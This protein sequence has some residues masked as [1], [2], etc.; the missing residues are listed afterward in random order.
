MLL[1]FLDVPENCINLNLDFFP[2]TS[3]RLSLVPDKVS[4]TGA[5]GLCLKIIDNFPWDFECR[6]K[7]ACAYSDSLLSWFS[8]RCRGLGLRLFFAFP[9]PDDFTRILR[10]SGW[11]H[12]RRK[13]SEQLIIDTDAVGFNRI[14]DELSEDFTE[15]CGEI[16]GFFFY[17]EGC[18]S[19]LEKI[20]LEKVRNILGD[21]GYFVSDN[22]SSGDFKSAE[23]FLSN[24]SSDAIIQ[25]AA[26]KAAQ[27]RFA[28]SLMQIKQQLIMSSMSFNPPVADT[29]SINFMIE[30][31]TDSKK[32]LYSSAE[33][34]SSASE[35]SLESEWTALNTRAALLAA[36]EDYHLLTAR[37]NQ[38]RLLNSD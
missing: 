15:L 24:G 22:I 9:G 16:D 30:E 19:E 1:L 8:E 10:L 21:T 23:W 14:I 26:F 37:L 28:E 13:D 29:V 11:R 17:S 32:L 35:G 31:L 7:G 25:F 27:S 38:A 4:E 2:S 6:M 36:D 18:N 33:K 5:E 12:L 20:Y 34:F 3:E